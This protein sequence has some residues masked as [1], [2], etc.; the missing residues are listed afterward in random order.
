MALTQA[1]DVP[2]T[3]LYDVRNENCSE[4]L[5]IPVTEMTLVSRV[6]GLE[7]SIVS[8]TVQNYCDKKDELQLYRTIGSSCKSHQQNRNS[9][10]IAYSAIARKNDHWVDIKRNNFKMLLTHENMPIP[11]HPNGKTYLEEFIIDNSK[12]VLNVPFIDDFTNL[13]DTQWAQG[14]EHFKHAY[15]CNRF[16]VDGN[17]LVRYNQSAELWA[18]VSVDK[19]AMCVFN[20]GESVAEDATVDMRVTEQQEICLQV[21][22]AH[23]QGYWWPVLDTVPTHVL[24]WVNQYN[25]R[26]EFSH[27]VYHCGLPIYSEKLNNKLQEVART[28]KLNHNT[29]DG[30]VLDLPCRSFLE[31]VYALAVAKDLSNGINIQWLTYKN[32]CNI[33]TEFIVE[34]KD[35]P[36][37]YLCG[38]T[39]AE[40]HIETAQSGHLNKV[41][42]NFHPFEKE[43]CSENG[44]LSLSDSP[45]A[46]K[47]GLMLATMQL[48][49]FVMVH[50]LNA[51]TL[52]ET[53]KKSGVWINDFE[54]SYERTLPVGY[55]MYFENCAYG[56]MHL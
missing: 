30:K 36:F 29:T 4:K 3:D 28:S 8:Q 22:M 16:A 45:L 37:E 15:R 5:D 55:L 44:S 35:V 56:V 12:L 54:S 32:F 43:F 20:C 19:C 2:L 7:E 24:K 53:V 27:C 13:S 50:E 1:I 34:N 39:P 49:I 14:R 21:K 42:N 40:Y 10:Y 11:N 23:F 51:T 46:I 31:G 52:M 47:T 9:M 17:Q 41:K 26:F 48:C 18:L 33:I 25:W 38:K 6:S